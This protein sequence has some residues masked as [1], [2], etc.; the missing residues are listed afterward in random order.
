M[1]SL[2]D[3]A[4][5]YQIEVIPE[6]NSF[7]HQGKRLYEKYPEFKW[8][9]PGQDIGSPAFDPANADA[10][11]LFLD[12]YQEVVDLFKPRY[13]HIGHDEVLPLQ[14]FP[15]D[16]AAGIFANNVRVFH[17]FLANRGIKTMMWGDM[18]LRGD[19]VS[20]VQ[21]GVNGG[22]LHTAGAIDLLP[23]DIT[24][25]DWHYVQE[26]PMFKS[27]AYFIDKGHP[28]IGA[29]FEDPQTT[30]RFASYLKTQGSGVM[31]MCATLW[32]RVPWRHLAAIKEIMS[33]SE[34]F[35]WGDLRTISRK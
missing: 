34:R 9:V 7:G 10:L 5:R 18:L 16:K 6:V 4:S 1:K 8:N 19:V 28:V 20:G 2:I 33:E 13:F 30:K 24:L 12:V 23:S 17:D 3:L 11:K 14:S 27:S 31:G 35:Y 32:Y 22:R 26:N 15:P 25:L 29:T 21:D